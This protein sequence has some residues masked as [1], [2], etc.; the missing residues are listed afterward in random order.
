MNEIVEWYNNLKGYESIEDLGGQTCEKWFSHVNTDKVFVY[1][2]VSR[3]N[4]V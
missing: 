1:N 2:D 4:N 3:V